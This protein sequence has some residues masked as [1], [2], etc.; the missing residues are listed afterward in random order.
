MTHARQQSRCRTT[1][2]PTANHHHVAILGDLNCDFR[3]AHPCEAVKRY[4][5]NLQEYARASLPPLSN[6]LGSID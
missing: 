5:S 3:H 1:G 6:A 2:R 4:S